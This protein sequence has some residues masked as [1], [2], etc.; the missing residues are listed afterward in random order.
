M[1]HPMDTKE[2]LTKATS[3]IFQLEEEVLALSQRLQLVEH[4]LNQQSTLQETLTSII[5]E[6]STSTTTEEKP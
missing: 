1:Q 5:S 3:Q 4:Y 6:I 2:V